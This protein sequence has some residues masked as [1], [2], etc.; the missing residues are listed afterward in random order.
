MHVMNELRKIF[1]FDFY[2]VNHYI[3]YTL[4]KNDNDIEKAWG[5]N[6]IPRMQLSALRAN[7]HLNYVR[8]HSMHLYDKAKTFF[9]AS[10]FPYF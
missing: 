3:Q 8:P 2:A 5:Q 1:W 9:P 4:K 6:L 7:V 10:W